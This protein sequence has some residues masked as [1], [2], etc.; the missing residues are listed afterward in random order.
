METRLAPAPLPLTQ[1]TVIDSKL[2]AAKLE[3]NAPNFESINLNAVPL[4]HEPTVP[5]TVSINKE[6]P[7][8]N[9]NN[10]ADR[11]TE[12]FYNG[13]PW[14]KWF[15]ENFSIYLNYFGIAFNVLGVVASNSSLFGKKTAEFLDEKSEAFS[16]YIIP[17]SFGWNAIEA[18]MGKR[19]LEMLSRAIPATLFWILPFYNLNLATGISSGLNY[20]FEHVKD[21]H[22]G[23]NPGE[24]D[25]WKNTQEVLKTSWDVFKDMFKGDQ[26]KEDW[27]KQLATVSL[28]LGSLGGFGLARD[29]RDSTL[30]RLFGNLRNIGGI[31]ADWKLVFNDDTN[32]QRKKDLRIVGGTC[33]LASIL[34]I[35]MR[36]VD[37]KLARALNHIAIAADDFGLTYWAQGSKRDNDLAQQ[38]KLKTSDLTNNVKLAT[39]VP[40]LHKSTVELDT[41]KLAV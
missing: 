39:P 28:L 31:F 35:L 33:S 4:I 15:R 16:K 41:K 40:A 6:T 37:P 19:P 26:S 25:R 27:P 11:F 24:G 17:F 7:K 14:F 13:P 38:S 3:E 22:G 20:L 36:W 32:Q 34:N 5:T 23:R 30:A 9:P 21:R 1:A 8:T 12:F 29:S 18:W 10:L 2:P